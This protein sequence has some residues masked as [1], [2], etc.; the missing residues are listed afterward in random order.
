MNA[1]ANRVL[2]RRALLRGGLL[3]GLATLVLEAT[4]SIAQAPAP[5]PVRHGGGN[6]Q[7]PTPL[8][9]A[10]RVAE[11]HTGGR[12]RKA[13]TERER[14]VYVYEIKTVSKDG[15]ATV[16]VDPVS[17]NVLR[18]HTP[19]F[20]ASIANVFDRDDQREDQTTFARLEAS[21][22]ALAGAIEAA[23]K[24]TGGRAVEAA[25]KSRG[26]SGLFEVRVVK[27][28]APQKVLVDPATGK[29]VAV[30]PHGGRKDDDD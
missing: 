24:E 9:H 21:S 16:L 5:Q 6:G 25:L 15:S 8:G 12:A 20:I 27:D 30:P 18:V 10:V 11:K 23:E 2:S 19:G 13:E 29:V 14:G 22:M 4:T 26:G 3:A 17:G 1:P 7:A 28:S